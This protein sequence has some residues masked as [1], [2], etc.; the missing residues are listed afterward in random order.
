MEEAI[1]NVLL[2]GFKIQFI[3]DFDFGEATRIEISNDKGYVY[4]TLV[5]SLQKPLTWTL[6]LDN[7]IA[8]HK[9][10]HP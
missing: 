5:L 9:K 2:A 7:L 6:V 10:L 1:Q 3:R 4:N 8:K